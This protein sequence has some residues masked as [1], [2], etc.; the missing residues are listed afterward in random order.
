MM[1]L[2]ETA[3]AA[4]VVQRQMEQEA[5]VDSYHYGPGRI[6]EKK[7]ESDA[8]LDPEF[9]RNRFNSIDRRSSQ[10]VS[11]VFFLLYIV[12]IVFSLRVLIRSCNLLM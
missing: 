11:F 5:A 2:Q 3:Q 12:M 7:R 1:K 4:E 6:M 10:D 8:S 9:V